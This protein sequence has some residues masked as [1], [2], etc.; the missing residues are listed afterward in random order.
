M[1]VCFVRCETC[2]EAFA[3]L[4]EGFSGG[5]GGQPLECMECAER[6][7]ALPP[8]EPD[9]PLVVGL[10]SELV[11]A[12]PEEPEPD[13][14]EG[15][16]AECGAVHRVRRATVEVMARA[17]SLAHDAARVAGALATAECSC[18]GAR[19]W[20]DRVRAMLRAA[21]ALAADLDRSGARSAERHP[22]GAPEGP[23]PGPP[24]PG[25]LSREGEGAR[26]AE[27]EGHRQE[28]RPCH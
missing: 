26:S 27:G 8:W 9:P 3:P 17:C 22:E 13:H 25:T 28:D 7:P 12:P 2:G 24:G 14:V 11:V 1:E 6:T 15:T 20:R 23:E 18:P 4:D 5:S 21:A 10:R 19:A 16:C